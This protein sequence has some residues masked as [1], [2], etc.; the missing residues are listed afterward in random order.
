MPSLKR[1]SRAITSLAKER[2]KATGMKLLWGTANLFSHERYM[3]G[4]FTNP[5]FEVLTYGGST[6]KGCN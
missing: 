4:A 6:D 1:T 3:N 2:Q 5:N